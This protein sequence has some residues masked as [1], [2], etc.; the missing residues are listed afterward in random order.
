MSRTQII[1]LLSTSATIVALLHAVPAMTAHGW[2][3]PQDSAG[4]TVRLSD[5]DRRDLL[6][7]RMIELEQAERLVPMNA[8]ADLTPES[9][10][11]LPPPNRVPLDPV[12][13]HDRIHQATVMIHMGWKCDRC[14]NWHG[15][16]ASGFVIHPDG[17]I[18]T[19]AHVISDIPEDRHG[20]VMLGD[21]RVFPITGIYMVDTDRDVAI[22]KVDGTQ[23][24]ALPLEQG[25]ARPGEPVHVL[26]HPQGIFYLFTQGVVSRLNTAD[27]KQSLQITAE[28]ATGSSGAPV[29]NRHGNVIGVVLST[30]TLYATR[31][32]DRH[33]QLVLRNCCRV[34]EIHRMLEISR[35]S[36]ASE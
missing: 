16:V 19:A 7:Q 23:L 1:R 31:D 3:L 28:F 13:L 36:S 14:D 22:V 20:S 29:V 6:N 30:R 21:E 11:V 15:G 25:D 10:P 26:S 27:P 8:T 9:F 5:S 35:Q 24:P 34:G 32:E 33:P 2:T 18:V 12:E 4:E 17:W